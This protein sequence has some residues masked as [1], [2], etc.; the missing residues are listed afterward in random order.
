MGP[1]AMLKG[2]LDRVWL[3][4]VAFTMA[5]RPVDMRPGLTR[6]RLIGAVSTLGAPWWYWTFVMGAPGRKILLRGLRGN[7]HLR[8][9]TF[10]LA[11]HDM[12]S[13][14]EEARQTFLR[15]VM[16]RISRIR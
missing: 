3:P 15:K 12:D 2:W 4:H 16:R 14:S 11:L 5:A 13:S 10:W 7:C 8:C 1:P 6:I 9:R